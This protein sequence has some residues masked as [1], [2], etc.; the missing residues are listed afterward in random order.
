LEHSIWGAQSHSVNPT[1]PYRKTMHRGFIDIERKRE[2]E[3]RKE[4]RS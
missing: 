1:I 2:K 3:K 4:K